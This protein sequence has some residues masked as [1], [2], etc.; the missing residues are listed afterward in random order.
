M[1]PGPKLVTDPLLQT[2]H[3]VTTLAS[4]HSRGNLCLYVVLSLSHGINSRQ[5]CSN[6]P[7]S[8][9]I[10]MSRLSSLSRDQFSTVALWCRG[11]SRPGPHTVTAAGLPRFVTRYYR[12]WPSCLRLLP[13][14]VPTPATFKLFSQQTQD[15]PSHQAP[16]R[17]VL[18]VATLT[19]KSHLNNLNDSSKKWLFSA[20]SA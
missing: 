15:F 1:S 14:P 13:A 3:L 16:P 8:I 20:N 10:T 4:H 17:P 18:M 9:D 6:S 7:H 11:P 19:F 5:G 12:H 2:Q